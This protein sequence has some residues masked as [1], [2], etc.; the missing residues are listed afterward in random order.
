M[1]HT[2]NK[3]LSTAHRT[4][5]DRRTDNKIKTRHADQQTE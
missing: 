5:T 3:G 4:K 1:L 2:H